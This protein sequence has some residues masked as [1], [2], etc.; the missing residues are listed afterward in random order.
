VSTHRAV[1]ARVSDLAPGQLL[2]VRV[3]GIEMIVYW[4]GD[5]VFAAQRRCLHQGADLAD[6]MLLRGSIVCAQHGWRF[7]AETGVHEMSV[8]NCLITY[9]AWVEGDEILVDTTP[10]RRAEVPA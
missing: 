8:E 5:R 3:E 6:G 7:D 2:P 9:R 1:V 4:M 10:I